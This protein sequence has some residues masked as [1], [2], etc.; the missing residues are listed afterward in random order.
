MLGGREHRGVG[1]FAL[2]NISCGG[3]IFARVSRGLN[4][5]MPSETSTDCADQTL[6][7]LRRE[8]TE[9]HRREAA[10]AEVLKV[11]SRSPTDLQ[12]VL[13]GILQSAIEPCEVHQAFSTSTTS[14][15]PTTIGSTRCEEAT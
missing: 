10:T 12:P 2:C 6:E 5:V 15:P 13:D 1:W 7:E 14:T 4:L 11:I 9:A 8:L 3:A